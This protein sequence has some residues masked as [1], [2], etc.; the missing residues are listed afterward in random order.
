MQ[1]DRP[2]EARGWRLTMAT[3]HRQDRMSS[4]DGAGIGGGGA[5]VGR[6]G[7]GGADGRH[8]ADPLRTWR[9]GMLLALAGIAMLFI[10]ITS[11]YIVRQ[12]LGPD[13]PR[14]ACPAC[15]VQHAAILLLPARRWNWSRRALRGTGDGPRWVT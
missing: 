1:T 14:S 8:P 10:A 2:L 6:G 9:L 11:A 5:P 4:R 12:G 3:T 7:G 13:W 15:R